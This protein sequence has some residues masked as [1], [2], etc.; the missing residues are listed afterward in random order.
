MIFLK[1]LF[2][3]LSFFL[4]SITFAL[5]ILK[6]KKIMNKFYLLI[7]FFICFLTSQ[8]QAP[9]IEWQKALGGTNADS[10]SD[11]LPTPDGGYIAIGS[12]VSSDGDVS[13]VNS[14]SNVWIVKMNSTGIIQWQRTYGGLAGEGASSIK[15][16]SDG[17]YIFAGRTYST[18]GVFSGNHGDSDV[19]LVKL[20]ASGDILWQTVLGG[21]QTEWVYDLKTTSDGGCIFV[22]SSKSNNGNLTENKGGA[23]YWIVKLNAVG[24]IQWQKSYGGTSD[25]YAQSV[26]QTS[27]NGYMILGYSQSNDGDVIGNYGDVDIWM[28]KL[29][30]S[31]N[32]LWQK[33][34]GGTRADFGWDI[35][36]SADGGYVILGDTDSND[37]DVV[38]RFDRF[39]DLWIVKLNASGT[40]VWQKTYGSTA[41]EIATAIAP[42]IDNGFIVS[43]YNNGGVTNNGDVTNNHGLADFW[44]LKLDVNGTLQWQKSFGGTNN[45]YPINVKQTSDGGY[46]VSGFTASNDGDVAGYHGNS[47]G[48]VIKLGAGGNNPPVQPQYVSL[49]QPISGTVSIN[50]NFTIQGQVFVAGLTDVIP[51]ITG[52]APGIQ[53]WIGLSPVG[54]NT[55]PASWSNWIPATHNGAYVGNNDEYFANISSSVSGTYY[56]AIRYLLNDGCYV[57]GGINSSGVGNFWDGVTYNS[58]VLTVTEP[59]IALEGTY[60]VL[61]E[62]LNAALGPY[63]F[64]NEVVTNTALN[65]YRTTNTANFYPQG[66]TPGSAGTV[67]ITSTRPGYTFKR[68]GYNILVENQLLFD[69]WNNP[70]S[71]T[72]AQFNASTYNPSTGVITVEYTIV[73]SGVGR[74]FRSTYNPIPLGTNQPIV[75]SLS[76]YPN[77]VKDVLNISGIE[78]DFSYEIYNFIGQ[79]VS[80]GNV[81]SGQ[82]QIDMTRLIKGNYIVRIILDSE[83]KSIKVIRD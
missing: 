44:I 48:W 1:K 79:K 31:G 59:V 28:I 58:G 17:G 29:D 55:N 5:L 43:G 4:L 54:Q 65:E 36:Q 76:F 3:V 70:I 12:T 32:L 62:R 49:S 45:D 8:A 9:A 42:T 73:F 25:E 38:G 39:S 33:N 71:Q 61:V 46:V 82:N 77:P 22:G 81:K 68:V 74:I 40:I 16:T 35:C 78:S 14:S 23:D 21:T 26:L 30:F 2:S 13:S 60:N 10:M 20:D 53:A 63:Y 47:D 80:F 7:V 66:G 50:T 11:I 72:P 37:N 83:I 75:N 41:T 57:Y 6:S 34:L 24:T 52:Q 69:Y 51:N 67:G 19:W 27:D 15:L 18:D 56:Y 64:T